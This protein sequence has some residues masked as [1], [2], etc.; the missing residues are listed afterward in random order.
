MAARC[1]C[2]VTTQH[3]IFPSRLSGEKTCAGPELLTKGYLPGGGAWCLYLYL[4]EGG[5]E[6]GAGSYALSGGFRE[7]QEAE[8]L[9]AIGFPPRELQPSTLRI[10]PPGAQRS[11]PKPTLPSLSSEE[12]GRTGKSHAPAVQ[13]TSPGS[14]SAGGRCC[15]GMGHRLATLLLQQPDRVCGGQRWPARP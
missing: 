14:S 8:F 4:Y 2:V 1:L 9:S 12:R 15:R 6:G 5:H 11:G 13:T 7:G 3:C 10:H